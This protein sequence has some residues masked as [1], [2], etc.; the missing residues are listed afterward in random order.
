D[1]LRSGEELAPPSPATRRHLL[2]YRPSRHGER[3]W[4]LP[5]PAFEIPHEVAVVGCGNC[6]SD[7]Y[8]RVPLTSVDQQS[9]AIAQACLAGGGESASKSHNR[10]SPDHSP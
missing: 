6:R 8:L 4:P 3:F 1:R 7:Q 9:E 5:K 2:L 10:Y